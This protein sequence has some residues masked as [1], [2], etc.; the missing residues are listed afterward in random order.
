M[1]S[2][3]HLLTKPGWAQTFAHET[4]HLTTEERRNGAQNISTPKQDRS[5]NSSLQN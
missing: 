2:S 4:E 1:A 3:K 5:P